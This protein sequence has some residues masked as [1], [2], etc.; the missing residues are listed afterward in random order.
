MEQVGNG[1]A[2][3]GQGKGRG[4][5]VLELYAQRLH[6]G[7][8]NGV[9]AIFGHLNFELVVADGQGG[10]RGVGAAASGRRE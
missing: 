10:R 2:V 9:Q 4:R 6:S 3:V 5:P 8:V 7:K 1:L